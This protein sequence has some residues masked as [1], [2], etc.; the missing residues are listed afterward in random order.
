MLLADV[1]SAGYSP[2]RTAAAW[3]FIVCGVVALLAFVAAFAFSARPGTEHLSRR[4]MTV[5]KIFGCLTGV[6]LLVSV[7]FTALA[8]F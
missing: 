2:Y 4:A 1:V 3:M 5:A 7:V 8:L 6:G